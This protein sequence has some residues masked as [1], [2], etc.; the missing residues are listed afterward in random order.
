MSITADDKVYVTFSSGHSA[1]TYVTFK[2]DGN[3]VMEWS[4]N[5]VGEGPGSSTAN[6]IAVD[7]SGN[8][9][10]TGV[11]PGVGTGNDIVTVQYNSQGQ[12][13]RVLRFNSHAAKND[14][15]RAIVADRS[16][17]VYVAGY[18]NSTGNAT[19]LVLIKY[20][21]LDNIMR[22]PD[23]V[24][25]LQFF[26]THGQVYRLHTSTNLVDWEELLS[27]TANS[28]GV[29]Q[30]IDADAVIYPHRFYRLSAQ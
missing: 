28:S 16:G 5:Y 15:G 1:G 14:A 11:S 7:G 25:E 8:S 12:Q 3:G 10:V 17:S 18:A 23:G 4:T 2:L 6:A 19:D 13:Q 20:S 9:C 30:F 26:G 29:V 21:P 24:V 27:A 22:R